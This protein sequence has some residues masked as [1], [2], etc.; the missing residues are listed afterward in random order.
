MK[1]RFY[2]ARPESDETG[3]I[4]CLRSGNQTIRIGSGI[5]IKS[6]QWNSDL[7]RL[8]KNYSTASDINDRLQHIATK[9]T[10]YFN[11]ALS[12][13]IE[14][15]LQYTREQLTENDLDREKPITTEPLLLETY[16][17]FID[18]KKAENVAPTTIRVLETT[19]KNLTKVFSPKTTLSDFA[20]KPTKNEQTPAEKWKAHLHNLY[21]DN[22][23]HK[24]FAVTKRFLHWATDRDLLTPANFAKIFSNAGLE[25]PATTIALSATELSAIENITFPERPELESVRLV[26]LLCC[27]SGLRISDALRVRPIHV[28]DDS[29]T[30]DILKTRKQ[31]TVPII[32]P[33]RKILTAMFDSIKCGTFVPITHT[34]QV[35][36]YLKIIGKRAGLT[37]EIT[38][39]RYVRNK[40]E[41]TTVQKFQVLTTHVGRRT[42]IT[43]S[44]ARGVGERLVMS[45]SGHKDEKSFRK[46]VKF[47]DKE[48]Q[49]AFGRAWQ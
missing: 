10:K 22:T 17:H 12:Q 6:E 47:S 19:Y 8:K 49:D 42:F 35:N 39:I 21:A 13:E 36:D 14:K 2:L 33:L 32:P 41:N 24:H 38:I 7:Q 43:Q 1:S 44:L 25:K 11:F 23:V 16:R 15:P 20:Q 46:Y 48:V 37:D 9:A 3:I 30:I 5:T 29:L 4:I 27:Y 31:H 18:A 34:Q 45:A 26:F 28:K 40:P